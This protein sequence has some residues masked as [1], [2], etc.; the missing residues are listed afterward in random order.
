MCIRDRLRTPIYAVTGITHLLLKE[1]P[2][3]E[4]KKHL[5]SIKFSGEHLLSL[6]N[7]ILDLNKLEADKV[8]VEKKAFN[9]KKRI[10]DVLFALEKSANDKGNKVHFQFGENIPK[11][12]LGDS[13]IISQVLINLI[14]NAIKFT[15]NGDIYLSCLLYTSPSPRDRTRSRMPSSA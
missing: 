3:E 9:L 4:Q 7:N 13:L 1:N 8:E 11:D 15:Q 6:I 5:N 14:G 10:Q 12:I 2:T